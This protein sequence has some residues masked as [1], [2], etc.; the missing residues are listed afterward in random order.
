MKK[1]VKKVATF[2]H[3]PRKRDTQMPTRLNPLGG[4]SL[5]FLAHAFFFFFFSYI[6]H[7]QREGG[8]REK[9]W[10]VRFK[11]VGVDD[12]KKLKRLLLSHTHMYYIEGG[13]Q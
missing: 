12:D 5:S 13:Q 11:G 1:G 9:R 7:Q 2:S 10:K 4:S 8:G 3:T 6:Q